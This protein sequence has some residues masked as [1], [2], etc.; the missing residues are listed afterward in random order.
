MTTHNAPYATNVTPLYSVGEE[1]FCT[2][3]GRTCTIY[4]VR[5]CRVPNGAFRVYYSVDA[6]MQLLGESWYNEK[7]FVKSDPYVRDR[8]GYCVFVGDTVRDTLFCRVST[9]FVVVKVDSL[10]SR[11]FLK[12]SASSK[13]GH[14]CRAR[15][16]VKI[17]C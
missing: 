8:L 13:F 16:A 3:L 6:D 9:D 4:G 7:C 5:V 2:R 14:W 10:S 12:T 17:A 11:V 1:V 15:D